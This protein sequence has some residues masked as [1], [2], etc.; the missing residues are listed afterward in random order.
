MQLQDKL[1]PFA[2][3]SARSIRSGDVYFQMYASELEGYRVIQV[4]E[5][6][7][8]HT[9]PGTTPHFQQFDALGMMFYRGGSINPISISPDIQALLA[10]LYWKNDARISSASSRESLQAL[11]EKLTRTILPPHE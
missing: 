1:F 8:M 4:A 11:H 6:G 9:V 2:F 10:I 5:K 7:F 3:P